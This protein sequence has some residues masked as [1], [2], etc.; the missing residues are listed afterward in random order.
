MAPDHTATDPT[1]P[2]K[3]RAFWPF[4]RRKPSH[5]FPPPPA[6]LGGS[7]PDHEAAQG[8]R[9]MQPSTVYELS[10]AQYGELPARVSAEETK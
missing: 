7:Y 5:V 6:E 1:D 3:K 9:L 2:E 4:A 10:A 8:E